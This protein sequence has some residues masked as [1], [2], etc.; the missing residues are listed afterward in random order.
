[1][2]FTVET[3]DFTM[4]MMDFTVETMDFTVE[5]M[6]FT[7]ETMDSTVE[8]DGFHRGN[9]EF[10]RNR[11]FLFLGPSRGNVESHTITTIELIAGPPPADPV[12]AHKHI[13]GG[14]PGN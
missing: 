9:D 12:Y 5:T 8:N 3:M 6:D 14:M 4:E 7:V 2:D 10:R 13:P 11:L 1:M